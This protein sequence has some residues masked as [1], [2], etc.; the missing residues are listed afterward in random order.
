VYPIGRVV[1]DDDELIALIFGCRIAKP[2]RLF[3]G[4]V[5]FY[6]F[7]KR[8]QSPDG[9]IQFGSNFLDLHCHP[10]AAS[11]FLTSDLL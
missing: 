9:L 3:K 6:Y 11:V 5:A 2:G 1:G 8:D 7:V 4:Q 10:C